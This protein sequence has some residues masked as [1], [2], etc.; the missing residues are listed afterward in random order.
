MPGRWAKPSI[1]SQPNIRRRRTVI[2]VLINTACNRATSHGKRMALIRSIFF[3]ST[4]SCTA[5][6]HDMLHLRIFLHLYWL[7]VIYINRHQ[8]FPMTVP[9]VSKLWFTADY[10]LMLSFTYRDKHNTYRGS[11]QQGKDP[12]YLP[13]HFNKENWMRLIDCCLHKPSEY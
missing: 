2:S 3:T 10:T 5:N 8:L 4:L 9:L 13:I 7:F 12:E 6:R 1:G 11:L